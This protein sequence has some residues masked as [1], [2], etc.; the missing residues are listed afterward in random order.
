MKI[1]LHVIGRTTHNYLNPGIEDYTRRISRY[2]PFEYRAIPDLKSTKSLTRVRQNE[3]EGRE[4]LKS[5]D[6][7]DYIILLDEHG[8]EFTSES[9][10]NYIERKMNAGHRR[11]VFAVGGPYGFS[12]EVRQRA[13]EK[14]SLSQMT[15]PHDLVRLVFLEQLYR[16][17]T[18]LHNE[19]YHHE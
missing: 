1:A 17:F 15:F 4:L 6:K 18:I 7:S 12:D 14:I 11:L 8:Q 10:S 16:A 9:F 19:P 13:N 5:F 2:I 3:L